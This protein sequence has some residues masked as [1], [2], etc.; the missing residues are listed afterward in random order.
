MKVL[1]L[2]FDTLFFADAVRCQ[3]K[4]EKSNEA[5]VVATEKAI[6]V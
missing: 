5:Q 4:P 6:E 2:Y 3:V 1:G